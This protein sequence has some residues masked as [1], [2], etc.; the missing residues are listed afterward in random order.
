MISPFFIY[1]VYLLEVAFVEFADFLHFPKIRFHA[2]FHHPLTIYS[3]A[4]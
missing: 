3:G 4:R 1:I 2:S